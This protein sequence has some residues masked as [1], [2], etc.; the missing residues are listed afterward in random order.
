MASLSRPNSP[1][2]T[3]ME[4]RG[5]EQTLK[6]RLP[7]FKNVVKDKRLDLKYVIVD[8]KAAIYFLRTRRTS[9]DDCFI[10]SKEVLRS[11]WERF[12]LGAPGFGEGDDPM[13]SMRFKV[14]NI[15]PEILDVAPNFK[16]SILVPPL[17]H[18]LQH[19]R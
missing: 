18:L 4:W 13:N 1:V 8:Q 10:Y 16:N 2:H 17:Y 7:S 5:D 9:A 14:G 19:I 3:V 15:N 12:H 11:D 6:A